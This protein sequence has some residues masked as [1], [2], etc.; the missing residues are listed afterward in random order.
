MSTV[1]GSVLGTT[2]IL[3]TSP[4][5]RAFNVVL[6]AEG[7]T[8]AQ[9]SDFND[10]CTK[11]VNDF[12]TTAPFGGLISGINIFRVN[13]S[14]TD[15]GADDPVVSDGGTGAT[16]NTYFDASFGFNNIQR[17]LV[18]NT[19]TALQVAT[20]QVPEF[21]ITIVVV[22]STI[23]GG[24]G[25]GVATY[26]LG[27]DAQ[28]LPATETAIHE[29]G[30][31]AFG[32]ADEYACYSCAVDMNKR[33]I[34]IGHDRHP[35]GEPTEPNVTTNTDRNTLKWRFTV[36]PTTALPTTSN[37]D[38][39]QVDR[40]S[41]PVP[42]GTVGL[43]EGAHYYH[44]GAY[45]PEFNCKMHTLG[46]P[47]CS[48]CQQVILDQISRLS[49]TNNL[50]QL[51]KTGLIW[52]YTDTPCSGDNCPGWQMLDKN[53]ATVAIAASGENLYQ[54]HKTGLIWK[55]T[56]IPCSG[57]SCP[58]WQM[59]DKNAATVA[60]AA[61]GNNLY[62]LHKTGLIWKYT[63]TPCSGD[64]CPG[65]LLLD[66]NLAAVA[67][68][69]GGNNLY[70]LR[71]TGI[72][73][74]YTDGTGWQQLDNNPATVAI[75]AS[76]NNLYQLHKTGLIWKY[77]GTPCSGDNCPGWQMLDNNSATVAIAAGG[78]ILYQ[79]HKT[80]LIWEY[81]GTPCS[82]DNCPGW[83]QLDNNLATV[84]IAADGNILYQVH[85]KGLIWKYT[86]TPCS[87]DNCPG[88]Q[89]LDNNPATVAISS[90]TAHIPR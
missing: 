52:K 83:Q 51:H 30:H 6:L 38:C 69:A 1:G 74:K 84:A 26:S 67:I 21:S 78:N 29:M 90:S 8:N 57:D 7:F 28:G 66:N 56:G 43:F 12:Q 79:L 53:A 32:L 16:A 73:L 81:T 36:F 59:L 61:S 19:T 62:Q 33:D 2:Q 60:I 5:N 72:I 10:A 48:V 9:Q 35:P 68:A 44:C 87:G 75:A 50:Y 37:P 82:G 47:F 24:S 39:S 14:S 20:A 40:R 55:Y 76:E 65:W 22:N 70:Q 80:G 49:F 11:F 31:T 27:V 13:V 34:E 64:S 71:K 45:R 25:G 23:Y 3:G 4:R 54:L 88:W 41:S 77:T 46:V 63:D 58:G 86:G 15:S 42:A 85:K 89:L 17:V 18:C